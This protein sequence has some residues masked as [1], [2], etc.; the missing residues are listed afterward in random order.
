MEYTSNYQLP[1]WAET[2][3]ILRT[4]FNDAYQKLDSALDGLQSGLDESSAALEGLLNGRVYLTGYTGTGTYGAANPV[5][6]VLPGKPLMMFVTAGE[7]LMVYASGTTQ[8]RVWYSA[9]GGG[10]VTTNWNGSR[11]SWYGTGADQQMNSNGVA[12]AV[13]ALYQ[14]A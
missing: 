13:M 12:F 5:T 14:A 1:V 8:A 7:H 11:F 2:D 10:Y 6:L 3:R 9:G 4:D